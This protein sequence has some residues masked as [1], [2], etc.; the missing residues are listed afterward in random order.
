M[1]ARLPLLLF[2][3][4]SC[5]WMLLINAVV[6]LWVRVSGANAAMFFGLDARLTPP[7][8]AVDATPPLSLLYHLSPF[9]K[10]PSYHAHACA[11]TF[12]RNLG[13][14]N[15]LVSGVIWPVWWH[16]RGRHEE[17]GR[18][19]KGKEAKKKQKTKKTDRGDDLSARIR[20]S[21]FF[22]P[23]RP[24]FFLNLVPRL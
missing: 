2:H 1:C 8:H 7:H 14:C 20:P 12:S 19:K 9:P 4:L 22:S 3:Q 13:A 5:V 15:F 16:R 6:R 17:M 10:S 23:F 21:L 24:R 18:K 11:D